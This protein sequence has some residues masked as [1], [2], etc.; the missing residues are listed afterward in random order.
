MAAFR[1]YFGVCVGGWRWGRTCDKK[2]LVYLN[3][4]IPRIRPMLGRSD[5]SGCRRPGRASLKGDTSCYDS[6]ATPTRACHG[7]IEHTVVT[8]RLH[9]QQA[10][11]LSKYR[12]R[13]SSSHERTPGGRT[14]KT[15]RSMCDT[16][17]EYQV[18]CLSTLL[19]EYEPQTGRPYTRMLRVLPCLRFHGSAD[20]SLTGVSYVRQDAPLFSCRNI[21]VY[22]CR[23]SP[24]DRRNKK[25]GPPYLERGR[26]GTRLSQRYGVIRSNLLAQTV[27]ESCFFIRWADHLEIVFSFL[28]SAHVQAGYI[29]QTLLHGQKTLF[30][31]LCQAGRI[32][33]FGAVSPDYSLYLRNTEKA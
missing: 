3:G 1:H 5:V 18:I 4:H 10:C 12:Q 7:L 20:Y 25:E 23:D 13:N 32:L 19:E 14:Q 11:L 21:P 31:V 26:C 6:F 8:K 29:A 2:K 27:F 33:L 17:Q 22:V 15:R 28:T 9:T 30:F 16:L 24:N